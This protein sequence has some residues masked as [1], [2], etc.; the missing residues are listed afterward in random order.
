M[1]IGVSTSKARCAITGLLAV[2]ALCVPPLSEA[3]GESP[4]PAA[5]NVRIGFL[6]P[7]IEGTISLGIYDAGGKLVRVLHRE[8]DVEEF[9]IGSDGLVTH[10]DGKDD[11]DQPLAAGRYRARGYAVGDLEVEGIEFYFN[12]WV[13]DERPERVGRICAIAA[14]AD[15]VGASARLHGSGG[16]T[17]ICDS[18][19]EIVATRAE[20]DETAC[21]DKP[22]PDD[23]REPIATANGK[24]HSRWVIVREND[25]IAVRQ[26][27]QANELL[28]ELNIARTEPQ[29]RAI[30]ASPDAD[31]IYLLEEDSTGERLRGLTLV[32]TKPGPEHSNSD[33]KVDFE[34]KISLHKDF[35]LQDGKP[36]TSGG[37][38]PPEKIGI[39]LALN[40]LHQD[41]KATIE[42]AAGIDAEGSFLKTADGLPLQTVSETSHLTRAIIASHDPKSVDLFQDDGAV[43]EQ[44]RVGKLDQ[45]MAF[46]CG[47]IE[48]K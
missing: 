6:P 23:T 9:E 48:L 11:A 8:S 36:V 41:E 3:A 38:P 15:G 14:A 47:E 21:D 24:D 20:S 46:D 12:D 22:V 39:K 45:M 25:G 31:R 33:W 2:V 18:K 27:S 29:P 42:L 13:S 16:E 5:R 7:P 32:E 34:K 10:W 17:L 1:S 43:V 28:R 35:T 4:A 37:T 19:G 30:A 26:Y 40:P 44:F